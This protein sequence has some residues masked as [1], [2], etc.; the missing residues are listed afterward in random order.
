[1]LHPEDCSIFVMFR[2]G[3]P[4]LWCHSAVPNRWSSREPLLA[5]TSIGRL[6]FM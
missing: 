4:A 3:M 2:K 6:Y 5:H 1:V